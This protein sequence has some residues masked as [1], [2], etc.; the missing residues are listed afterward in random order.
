VAQRG[1]LSQSECEITRSTLRDALFSYLSFLPLYDN[2]LQLYFSFQLRHNEEIVC[3]DGVVGPHTVLVYKCGAHDFETKNL[4][5]FNN[6]I[7][8]T[9]NE[10]S[11]PSK[12]ASVTSSA[13]KAKEIHGFS[14]VAKSKDRAI[15]E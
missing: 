13:N 14:Y 10:G 8:K 4:K 5:E 1:P 6:H 2:Y 3:W 11:T 9:H 7:H 15:K 12:A